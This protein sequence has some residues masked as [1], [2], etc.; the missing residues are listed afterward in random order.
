MR[1][2]IT[3]LLLSLAGCGI[4]QVSNLKDDNGPFSL[5]VT[6]TRTTNNPA[7][8]IKYEFS[9]P[10]IE[11]QFTDRGHVFRNDKFTSNAN[12]Y[13]IVN[14]N[15]IEAIKADNEGTVFEFTHETLP[16]GFEH[17]SE[18][19]LPYTNGDVVF[20][21]GYYAIHIVETAGGLDQLDDLTFKFVDEQGGNVIVNGEMTQGSATWKT[22][23]KHWSTFVYFGQHEPVDSA[24]GKFKTILD[25]DLPV[26][27]NDSFGPTGEVESLFKYFNDNLF[28]LSFKPIIFFPYVLP[29]QEFPEDD[30]TLTG[31]VIRGAKTT[32]MGA[33]GKDYQTKDPFM[34]FKLVASVYSHENIHLWNAESVDN[35]DDEKWLWEGGAEI[36]SQY[37]TKDLGYNNDACFNWYRKVAYDQC[38]FILKFLLDNGVEGFREHGTFAYRCGR[39]VGE[40]AQLGIKAKDSSKDVFNLWSSIF[41]DAISSNEDITTEK[42][43]AELV[44]VVDD[45]DVIAATNQILKGDLDADLASLA[46]FEAVLTKY[47]QDW[48]NQT[49]QCQ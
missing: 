29:D 17:G 9:K 16:L 41:K 13:A 30:K 38:K 39:L 31:R 3:L 35:K 25:P 14:N 23:I 2:L 24:S 28:P 33:R 4:Y 10:I 5:L 26:W 8:N 36:L 12:N 48:H 6:V 42:Y 15:G 22:N 37:A 7:W 45:S 46:K 40:L 34:Y 20:Y 18:F 27:I 1:Y 47:N 32:L 21:S 44:K 43:L 11:A 19:H 49:Y